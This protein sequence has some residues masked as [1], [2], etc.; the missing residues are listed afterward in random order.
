MQGNASKGKIDSNYE[1]V[2][3]QAEIHAGQGGFNIEVGKNTDMK[4]AVISSDA[5]PDK[6]KISTDTMSYSD[7]KNKADYSASSTGENYSA[8][9]GVEK[10]DKGWSPLVGATAEGDGSSTTKSA[11]ANGTIKIRSNP[12]QDLSGLSRDTT[13]ALNE[14]GKIFDKKKVQEQQELA[15]LFGQEAYKA[16]GDLALKQYTKA[17]ADA[18]KA[19]NAGND[20]AYQDAIQ[21]KDAWAIGGKNEVILHTL[22][23]GVMSDLSGSGFISGAVG[24]GAGELVAGR[25]KNLSPQLQKIGSV[26][27]GS[28]AAKLV[29]GNATTGALTSLS[30][31]VNNGLEHEQQEAFA[32]DMRYAIETGSTAQIMLTL[33]K[34]TA[35]DWVNLGSGEGGENE[36][37]YLLNT[38]AEIVGS[39]F[40]YNKND[41]LHNNIQAFWGA[42]VAT[43]PIMDFDLL[44]NEGESLTDTA[45]GS[46]VIDKLKNTFTLADSSIPSIGPATTVTMIEVVLDAVFLMEEME[47]V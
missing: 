40:C 37:I 44:K 29:G 36:T 47:L 6:N 5:T 35:E 30:G 1:S 20:A 41:S 21:R 11:I 27:V 38:A 14:L 39:S 24:A 19:K 23:G 22:V 18:V 17:C 7:I 33:S 31:I 15:N 13:N 12:K 32:N 43:L 10:K 28:I 26:L 4:G 25:L 46:L 3:T 8:G 16:V 42:Q 2:T 34:Y 9:S 45:L